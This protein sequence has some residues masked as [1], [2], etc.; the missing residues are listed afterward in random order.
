MALPVAIQ[1]FSI[2]DAMQADVRTALEKVK[3]MGYD[4]VEFAGLYGYTPLEMK[5]MCE[6]I[7][8]VPIS[9][10]VSFAEMLKNPAIIDDYVAI[11]CEY[12]TMPNLG[13][14]RPW[15]DNYLTEAVPNVK[16]VG[17]MVNKAGKRLL[18]H[19]HAYELLKVNG[20]F[21]LD[22][23]YRSVPAEL[24]GTQF[25]TCWVSVGGGDP[26]DFLKRYSGRSPVVHLKDYVGSRTEEEI[27]GVKDPNSTFE[28]RPVGSGVQNFPEIIKTAEEC[29]T[30]WFVVEQDD[31]SMGLTS[32]QCAQKSR[33]YLK[34]IGN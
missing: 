9:A 11:G 3:T 24:L 1:L 34:S 26:V 2:R 14:V 31:P 30:K 5:A 13:D 17:E 18:Y 29:G 6:E 32:M 28:L 7:G 25:D 33:E 16:K 27:R 22:L 21:G 23:L 20:G 12:I 10:H 8:L 19:N 4:G 15:H